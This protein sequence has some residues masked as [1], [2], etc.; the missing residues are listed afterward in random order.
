MGA[1][2]STFSERAAA[3]EREK[4]QARAQLFYRE[5]IAAFVSR[6][7]RVRSGAFVNS[8]TLMYAFLAFC[9]GEGPLPGA[10]GAGESQTDIIRRIAVAAEEASDEPIEIMIQHTGRHGDF[11]VNMELT[12]FP[13]FLVDSNVQCTES[14][15]QNARYEFVRKS[16]CSFLT[17]RRFNGWV[18]LGFALSLR[19][20]A[21]LVG[22]VH[23]ACRMPHGTGA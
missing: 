20:A 2:E 23:S 14:R 8:V 1:S 22:R 4:A 6:H 10:P 13:S 7:V 3:S 18:S 21:L 17:I 9:D 15:F 12:S 16:P 11:V 19:E 5:A